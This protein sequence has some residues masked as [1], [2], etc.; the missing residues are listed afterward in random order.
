M[1]RQEKNQ[2]IDIQIKTM[3]LSGA[4]QCI[5]CVQGIKINKNFGG[6][7]KKNQMKNS[8]I[9]TTISIDCLTTK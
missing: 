5:I 4:S 3:E 2:K 9:E 8:R 1:K 7:L 6:K